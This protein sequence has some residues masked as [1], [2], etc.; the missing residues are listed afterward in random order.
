MTNMLGEYQ[1]RILDADQPL[2]GVKL[3]QPITFIYHYQRWELDA[4]DLDPGR[5]I[6]SWPD[7]LVADRKAHRST[8][9]DLLTLARADPL[10]QWQQHGHDRL[11]LRPG[12]VQL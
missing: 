10:E 7:Q 2:S 5:L 6:M 8:T 11:R 1:M 3:R 4:L 9:R 12:R